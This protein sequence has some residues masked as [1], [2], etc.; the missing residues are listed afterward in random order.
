MTR[1]RKVRRSV[2]DDRYSQLIEALYGDQ[3]TLGVTSDIKYRD[4]KA[5]RMETTVQIK[6]VPDPR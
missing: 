1:T 4:G 3:D 5:F 2:V 6:T